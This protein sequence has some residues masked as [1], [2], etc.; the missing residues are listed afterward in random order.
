MIHEIQGVP[1]KVDQ[2]EIRGLQEKDLN[3]VRVIVNMKLKTERS[4]ADYSLDPHRTLYE[5][6]KDHEKEFKVQQSPKDH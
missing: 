2:E 3:Y 4:K 5:K 1:L 6:I